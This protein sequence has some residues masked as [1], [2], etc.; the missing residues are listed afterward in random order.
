MENYKNLGGNSGIAG[1]ELGVDYIIVVFKGGKKP[2]RWSF[3]KVGGEHIE[4]MKQLAIQGSGLN[5][6]IMLNVKNDF[7]K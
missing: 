5:S 2:Y 3:G 1:Y 4:N 7:D 6:Y